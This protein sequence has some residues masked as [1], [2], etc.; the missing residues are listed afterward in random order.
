MK[1]TARVIVWEETGVWAAHLRLALGDSSRSVYPCRTSEA[2]D[3]ALQ[4][5]P[6]SLLA[7]E[8]TAD[9]FETTLAWLAEQLWHR[10]AVRAV[11]LAAPDLRGAAAVIR[12]SGAIDIAFG[13][14]RMRD[15]AELS[16]R[17][18]ARAAEPDLRLRERIFSRLPWGD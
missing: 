13:P 17:H 12:E 15:I 8:V 7:I 5:W 11:A 10:P 2:C 16:R 9:R 6:A 18:L 1:Q 4:R 14:R 3:E